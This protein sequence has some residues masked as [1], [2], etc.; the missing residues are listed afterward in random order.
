MRKIKVLVVSSVDPTS[1]LSWSGTQFSIY[2]QLKKYYDVNVAIIRPTFAYYIDRVLMLFISRKPSWYGLL[3]S[4]VASKRAQKIMKSGKYDVAFI[5]GSANG[6]FIKS[7]IP[8]V[9]YTDAT[10]NLLHDYYY[11]QNSL[12]YALENY[13]NRSCLQNTTYNLV[14][15]NWAIND[16]VNNYGIPREKCI[17]CRVGANTYTKVSTMKHQTINIV[18]IGVDWDRKGGDIAISC[19]RELNKIDHENQYVLHIIG[20]T[21]PYEVSE[22]NIILHGFIN[23]NNEEENNKIISILNSGDIFLLPTKAECA[24]IVFCEAS[25]YGMVIFTHDTGGIGDYVIN[26]EN[27]YRLPLG[28]SGADFAEAIKKLVA[29][30]NQLSEM[31]KKAFSLYESTLNW[32]ATGNIIKKVIDN[33]AKDKA[34][35]Q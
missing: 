8:F 7:S 32:N 20:S 18:F 22:N 25:A 3:A 19:M 15:S 30:P 6:A 1:K 5:F 29:N 2:T 31:R 17:L 10:T 23:R 4:Y 11:T 33:C 26:G 16:M 13:I 28:A 14:A 24:G 27:G 9:H 21:P 34:I 35:E 12:V